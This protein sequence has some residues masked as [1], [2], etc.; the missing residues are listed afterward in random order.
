MQTETIP[1]LQY[2][3]LP[4][5]KVQIENTNEKRPLACKVRVANKWYATSQR[6]WTSFFARFGI[7]DSI[8]KYY[9]H[10]EV[11]DRICKV[12]EETELR[13]CTD[14]E[15]AL[16]ISNPNKPLMSVNGFSKL[17]RKFEGQSVQYEAGIVK[18]SYTP[19]SG[20]RQF[21]I[22]PDAFHN[23]FM[24]ET[25]MDG[26]GKPSIY[27]TL[28]RQVCSNGAV[29][30]APAFRT[31]V[32]VGDNPEYN[33]DRALMSFDS[34]EG[35]SALRDRFKAAQ[36]SPASLWEC[37]KL[38]KRMKGLQHKEAVKAYE[39]VVGDIYNLYGVANL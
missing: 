36:V 31:D 12:K 24:L 9:E 35:Y 1:E 18:S 4:L 27:L 28:L 33:L 2:K 16:A 6:F 38:Y 13:F 7:S 29:A 30:Y 15:R 21:K 39:K 3:I 22:G 26:Y 34:D 20:E 11:F 14:G 10:Q 17:V 5:A 25:P 8:F 23:R 37:L 19:A 32:T